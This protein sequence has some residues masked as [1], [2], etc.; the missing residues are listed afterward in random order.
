MRD[1]SDG[2]KERRRWRIEAVKREL[3]I[4]QPA[5]AKPPSCWER[6]LRIPPNPVTGSFAGVR[7][8]GERE[9]WAREGGTEGE[10]RSV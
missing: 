9:T 1:R 10:R 2:E 7:E 8:T 6:T 3:E 4:I 5:E